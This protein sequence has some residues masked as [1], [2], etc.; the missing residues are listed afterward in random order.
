MLQE[1]RSSGSHLQVLIIEPDDSLHQPY[2]FLPTFYQITR[3]VTTEQ[4]LEELKRGVP[5]LILLSAVINP[6]KQ[7]E[8]LEA[9]KKSVSDMLPVLLLV[10]NWTKQNWLPTTTWGGKVSISHSFASESELCTTLEKHNLL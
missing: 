9:V 4:A 2:A 6:S 5:D 10:A 1:D 8:F 7:I 3:V